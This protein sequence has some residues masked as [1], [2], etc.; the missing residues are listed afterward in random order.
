[1]TNFGAFKSSSSF[2]WSA[3]ICWISIVAV[4]WTSLVF[5]HDSAS[6]AELV[7]PLMWRIS[8]VY[9]NMKS[10][11][12]TS[13]GK[14][15]SGL[16][17]NAYSSGLKSVY[18]AKFLPSSMCRKCLPAKYG[19]NNSRLEML[20]FVSADFNQLERKDNGCHIPSTSCSDTTSNSKIG[21]VDQQ[22]KW[23]VGFQMKPT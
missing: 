21:Y 17:L 7:D 20:H 15:R 2:S 13:L 5:V 11:W 18:M 9:C 22:T 6:A 1:M 3:V 12:W 4:V 10:G 8:V 23:I 19:V 14:R 16:V